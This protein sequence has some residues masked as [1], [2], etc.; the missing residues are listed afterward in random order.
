MI[1]MRLLTVLVGLILSVSAAYGDVVVSSGGA[2]YSWGASS[3]PMPNNA[4]AA[5]YWD[6]YSY[7]GGS[8]NCNIGFWL[9]SSITCASAPDTSSMQG[10][11]VMPFYADATR[12]NPLDFTFTREGTQYNSQLRIEIAGNRGQNVFGW[13]DTKSPANLIQIFAGAATP[14]ATATFSPS[15][16]FGFYLQGPG[17]TFTTGAQGG[18]FVL[19]APTTGNHLNTYYL[20]VEDLSL[21]GTTDRDYNDMFVRIDVI[22]EPSAYLVLCAGMAGIAWLTRR[23][24]REM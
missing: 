24:R 15:D 8:G 20:A 10:P 7:D 3:D 19:F 6:N 13:Y 4:G 23:R 1:V 22:P 17:G 18:Q 11:A 5:G 16:S 12:S 14:G 2:W 9:M 21:L